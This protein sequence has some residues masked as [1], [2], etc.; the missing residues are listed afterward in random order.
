MGFHHTDI[1]TTRI[2]GELTF[3]GLFLLV[4]ERQESVPRV[5]VT[6]RPMRT[7]TTARCL[8]TTEMFSLT[9]VEAWS[10]KP[11]CQQDLTPEDLEKSPFLPLSVCGSLRH[12]LAFGNIIP[13]SVPIFRR[14]SS[15]CRAPFTG[16]RA[17][18]KYRMISSQDPLITFANT[19]FPNNVTL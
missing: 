12:F 18:S 1:I 16:F 10:S 13:I 14:P 4:I 3:L 15:S 9:V 11:R 2:H 7:G 6:S 19:L 17:Y 5:S 8:V